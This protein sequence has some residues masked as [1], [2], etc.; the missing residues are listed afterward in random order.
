M[1]KML[2]NLGYSLVAPTISSSQQEFLK[3]V[4]IISMLIA[5]ISAIFTPGDMVFYAIGRIA[6]PMFAFLM[7]YSYIYH[8][9]SPIRYIMRILVVA[10]IAQAPYMLTL[11]TDSQMVNIMFT[12]ASG[13]FI[14][15]MLDYI[16]AEKEKIKQYAVGYAVGAFF[17]ASGAFVDYIWLGLIVVIAFWA[18]LRFPSHITLGAAIASVAL[19]NF[20]SGA[21]ITIAGLSS[22]FIIGVA[23]SFNMNIK[24][25]NKW[26]YYSFYPLHL[27]LLH[28]ARLYI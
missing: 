3:I 9:S 10:V 25:M 18:W 7:A 17:L 26:V 19:L 6:F 11:G 8:T 27:F 16:I 28:I 12:L 22:F 4:A 1:I 13:L 5:H 23:M 15:Y 2:G 21:Y 14:V 20:P 24:R